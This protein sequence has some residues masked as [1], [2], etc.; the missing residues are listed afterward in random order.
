[1][2]RSKNAK[3]ESHGRKEKKPAQRYV[4]NAYKWCCSYAGRRS[5]SGEGGAG[6]YVMRGEG[7]APNQV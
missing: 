4:R 3:S 6:I 7:A 5:G 2:K 1:M